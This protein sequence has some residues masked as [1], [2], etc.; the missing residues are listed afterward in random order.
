MAKIQEN[1]ENYTSTIGIYKI[2]PCEIR[3]QTK[4]AKYKFFGLSK[5]IYPLKK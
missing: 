4:F 5:I 2:N 3:C 1:H